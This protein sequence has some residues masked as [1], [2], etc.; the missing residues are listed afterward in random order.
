MRGSQSILTKIMYSIVY[1]QDKEPIQEVTCSDFETMCK[2]IAEEAENPKMVNATHALV[3][4]LK[5]DRV[6]KIGKVY[7]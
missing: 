5:G 6:Y 2:E 7:Y 3:T 4:K 1:F